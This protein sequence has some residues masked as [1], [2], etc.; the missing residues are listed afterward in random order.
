MFKKGWII[1]IF[2]E[3][4]KKTSEEKLVAYMKQWSQWTKLTHCL[5]DVKS[6]KCNAQPKYAERLRISPKFK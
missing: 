6:L 3:K 2:I 4:K 1:G 5:K